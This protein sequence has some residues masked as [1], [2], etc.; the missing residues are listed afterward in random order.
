M[1]HVERSLRSFRPL[2]GQTS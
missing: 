1:V 2:F